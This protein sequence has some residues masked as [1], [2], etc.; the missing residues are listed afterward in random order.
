MATPINVTANFTLPTTITVTK[1]PINAVRGIANRYRQ[2]LTITNPLATAADVSIGLSSF[3]PSASLHST[4]T[5]TSTTCLPP[6][7]SP[8][9]TLT[10]VPANTTR[11]INIDFNAP[12]A[13]ALTYATTAIA[14]PGAR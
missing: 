5:G 11:S 9:F 7:S 4:P 14:G 12:S 8:Y 10:A 1:G 3:G 6:A 13:A 2:T